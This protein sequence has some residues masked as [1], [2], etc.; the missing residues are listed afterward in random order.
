MR[1]ERTSQEQTRLR[2]QRESRGPAPGRGACSGQ[3][4]GEPVGTSK[5]PR[6]LGQGWKQQGSNG[7]EVRLGNRL[8]E[9]Y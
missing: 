8:G 5:G 2:E 3:A 9:K 7:V 1:E 6:E 4:A